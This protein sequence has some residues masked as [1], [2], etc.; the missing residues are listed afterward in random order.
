MN[1][2][3]NA[4][5]FNGTQYNVIYSTPSCYLNAVYEATKGLINGPIKTDDFFPY[6]TSEHNYW[7]GYYSS[8]PTSKRYDKYAN[9]FLQVKYLK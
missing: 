6:A 1:R 5:K 9:N 8:R 3:I 7:T 4:N 2:Y